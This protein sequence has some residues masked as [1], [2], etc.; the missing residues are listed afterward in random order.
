MGYQN[1]ELEGMA[2][3]IVGVITLTAIWGWE[4]Y[5]KWKKKQKYPYL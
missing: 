3:F 4:T 5:K 1:A 2:V